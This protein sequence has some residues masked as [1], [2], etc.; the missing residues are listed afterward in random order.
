MIGTSL[1]HFEITAKLGEGGMGVVWLADDTKLGR[2]VAL[3]VLPADVAGDDERMARFEREAKV[4]A[5]LNHPNIAHL[6]G[7]ETVESGV[8]EGDSPTPEPITSG[9]GSTA[10][11]TTFLVMELVEGEDLSALIERGAVPVDEAVRIALQIAEAL[12]AAHEQGIV[13][14]DLKPANIKLRPDGTVKVLDFGLAKA[15]DTE[16]RDGSLSLSPTLTQHAT[17]AGVILGTAAYMSPEQ[18]A[19]V[20]ADRRADIWAFGVVLWEM[21]TGHKLFEGETVSH[22]L[23]SVLKDEVDV[24]ELPDDTP[25]RVHDLLDRCLRKK[26]RERLQAIGDARIALEE[27]QGDPGGGAMAA[28]PFEHDADAGA[29]GRTGGMPWAIAALGVAAAVVLAAWMVLHPAPET[30]V[31]RFTVE[32]PP[33]S[34]FDLEPIRPGPVAVSPDGTKLVFAAANAD[35]T[36]QLWIRTIDEVEARPLTGTENAQYPFWAPDSR[37]IG[38]F[39]G[40]SLK[41]VDSSGGLP[42]T[43]CDAPNG[44][45]GSWG[46][47]GT[48]VFAPDSDDPI[49]AVSQAGGESEAV[50]TFNEDRNEDSHRHPWFL[51]DGRRFLYLAM[52][53]EGNESGQAIMV[54]SLD[55]EPAVEIGRSPTNAAYASGHLLYVRESTLMARPFDP[56]SLEFGGEAVPVVEQVATL[57]SGTGRAVFS[58]SDA[59][60]LVSQSGVAQAG[61]ILRWRDRDGELIEE[62][63]EPNFLYAVELSPDGTLAVVAIGDPESGNGDLWIL[64]LERGLLT[65]FTSDEGNEYAAIWSADG[66]EI[67]YTSAGGGTFRLVRKAVEGSGA[68]HVLFES[69]RNFVVRGWGPDEK[70]LMLTAQREETGWDQLVLQPGG[71]P[72]IK[73]V[74]VTEFTEGSGQLSPDGRWLVYQSDASG[75]FEV[76]V[77][78]Y[79]GPGRTLRA[80]TAGGL[81]PRWNGDG[82]EI[83]YT[84]FT[85]ALM[86]VPVRSSGTGLTLAP[87]LDLF[88]GPSVED[89]GQYDVADDGRFLVIE[90]FAEA[91]PEP[92]MV[93]MNWPAVLDR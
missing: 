49:H 16:D 30:P 24:A 85:G 13:H 65:R 31:V 14:R 46:P 3:K 69:E 60:T 2:Q 57:A 47:D 45:G 86:S 64:E 71:E 33:E 53:P 17:A 4:L 55:D 76:Y 35:G 70:S 74:V 52:F 81:W 83:Y 40:S 37:H 78:P 18:A 68:G 11:G 77:Q 67:V 6:Y 93:L 42:L 66:S 12:E 58:P 63:G 72:E 21:L 32:P 38:F 87:A 59:G 44:K 36:D 19:G 41:R 8:G 90:S 56:S 92:V 29:P 91:D 20:A 51:P 39:D 34:S 73:D 15:W 27:E 5:S 80:S 25:P 22:V 23:A 28:P 61:G 43:L 79:P 26:P 7:L 62:I 88:I 89:G 54:G 48:I 1:A 75:R 50:T 9:T 82:T 84:S 10:A